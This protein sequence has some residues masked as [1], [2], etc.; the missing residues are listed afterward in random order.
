MSIKNVLFPGAA[1]IQ[2]WVKTSSAYSDLSPGSAARIKKSIAKKV[3]DQ[4]D[5]DAPMRPSRIYHGSQHRINKFEPKPHYLAN[6]A[7]VVFGTPSR[8]H[9]IA[10]MAPWDD[11]DF[12]QSTY[13]DDPTVHMTE[14]YPGAF[15]KVYRG[16]KGYLYEL[17]PS[18][19]HWGPQLMRTEFIS[20]KSPSIL[21]SEEL[22]IHKAMLEE[23]S[24][25]RLKLHQYKNPTNKN[26]REK[27]AHLDKDM[28]AYLNNA[29]TSDAAA[30]F[31]SELTGVEK[32]YR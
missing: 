7:P 13:G 9:S 16:Q 15:E 27:R 6:D 19:F 12:D 18:S 20:K 31:F 1:D 24:S 5:I 28:V 26:K 4:R 25:G 32:V 3:A 23:E 30:M 17:D 14:K 2:G 29:D 8:T 22:D 11:S 10:F 21:K